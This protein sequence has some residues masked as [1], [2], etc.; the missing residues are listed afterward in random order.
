MVK[1]PPAN[2]GDMDLVCGLV[3]FHMK[4]KRK[5]ESVSHS[6][7]SNS[8]Q[9]HGLC[10]PGS[11]CQWNSPG[12]NNGVGTHSFLQR[13]FLTQGLNPALLTAGRFFTVWATR[14][15]HKPWA[16]STEPAHPSYWNLH[17]LQ[18]V[19]CNKRSHRNEK[20]AYCNRRKSKHST[21]DPVQPQRNV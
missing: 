11:C 5:S 6:V 17:T 13:I 19:L 16:T 15:A 7:M 9:L 21:E 1:N 14:E 8:L 12:K 20:P 4:G 2:A 18:P 10:P 3:R